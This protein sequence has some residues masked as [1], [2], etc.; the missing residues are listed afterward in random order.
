[1][2][3]ALYFKY[4]KVR[5]T[6]EAIAEDGR[7]K[8]HVQNSLDNLLEYED[9]RLELLLASPKEAEEA[10]CKAGTSPAP[11]T[12]KPADAQKLYEL[13][14]DD[15][16][17]SPVTILGVD[18]ASESYVRGVRMLGDQTAAELTRAIARTQ[19]ARAGA[20]I[21]EDELT[22]YH[23]S[24]KAREGWLDGTKLKKSLAFAKKSVKHFGAE[25][26]SLALLAEA[27]TVIKSI[28][29]ARSESRARL[30]QML[31]PHF[32]KWLAGTLILM[33]TETMW[34]VLQSYVMTLPQI[35]TT[36]IDPQT[37]ARAGKTFVGVFFAYF[38]NY[39]IDTLADCLVD[40]VT[41]EVELKLRCAV[42]ST[43]LAQ[44]REYFDAHQ[45]GELQERLNRDTQVVANML[46]Q[47]PKLIFSVT[48]R[49]EFATQ[50]SFLCLLVRFHGADRPSLMP[51]VR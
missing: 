2:Y 20:K 50:L 7:K 32:P 49:S 14:F 33:Y 11:K 26:V 16:E 24:Y 10:E 41:A 31:V 9:E 17:N 21:G 25:M 6:R 8:D 22:D 42:M 29:A 3:A 36:S 12:L 47:Q 44:D 34:G 4:I 38:M 43:V 15:I 1:M 23:G 5:R 27:K 35:L 48:T 46:T 30:L 13:L 40:D 39:P 37:M 45:V 19:A 51:F 28:A 18:P